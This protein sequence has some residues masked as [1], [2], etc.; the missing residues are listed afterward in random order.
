MSKYLLP[1]LTISQNL[2]AVRFSIARVVTLDLLAVTDSKGFKQ[3][4]ANID[5]DQDLPV[6]LACHDRT[7]AI[8]VPNGLSNLHK[9]FR[10]HDR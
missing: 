6:E 9:D 1:C 3:F 2:S 5:I 10:S 4:V 7:R 8:S